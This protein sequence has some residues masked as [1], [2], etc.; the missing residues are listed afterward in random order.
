[1]AKIKQTDFSEIKHDLTRDYFVYFD[2]PYR[3]LNKTSNFTSYNEYD[4]NEN[5]QIRLASLYKELAESGNKLMLSNSDPRNEDTA[6][7]F[8][9]HHY[10]GYNINKVNAVRMINCKGNKRGAISELLITNYTSNY[11]A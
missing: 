6:D 11:F 3:P 7:S 9:E 1:M 10:K 2:P 5:D 8:F 4:F